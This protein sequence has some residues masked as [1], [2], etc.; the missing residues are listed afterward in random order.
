MLLTYAV[1]HIPWHAEKF[2]ETSH[3][4]CYLFLK[5][6]LSH[7]FVTVHRAFFD[8]SCKYLEFYE[9][10]DSGPVVRNE[11]HLAIAHSL[12]R[13]IEDYLRIEGEDVVN[14]NLLPFY[15]IG[16]VY[17]KELTRRYAV[18]Y[19]IA[20]TDSKSLQVLDIVL[21]RYPIV[22]DQEILVAIR[23]SSCEVVKILLAYRRE[24]RLR[25]Q[26]K[27]ELEHIKHEELMHDSFQSTLIGPF[28]AVGKWGYRD[29]TKGITGRKSYYQREKIIDLFLQRGEDINAQC[30]P[31]GTVL[32]S[33]ADALPLGGG[34]E[35]LDL[36][37]RKVA[38][39]HVTGLF[40]NALE[41][42]LEACKCVS[43]RYNQ[44]YLPIRQHD[45]SAGR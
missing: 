11:I 2:E 13:Y 22:M 19:A 24:R 7:E 5:D 15:D 43:P 39:V 27:K 9:Y 4:S 33:L 34:S 1:A 18:G 21:S 42:C 32:H 3:K 16:P 20:R 36:L 30:G 26:I 8:V 6:V 38:D 37:L 17:K 25:P 14:A 45:R 28:W 12:C 40:G 29:A 31:F 23:Y 10:V 35:L 44:M 41:F